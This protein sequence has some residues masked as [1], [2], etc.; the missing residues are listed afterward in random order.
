MAS[1]NET[2]PDEYLA[3]LPAE[4]REIVSAV[5]A[6]ILQHLPEGYVETVNW[7]ML[8]FEIPLS[9]FPATRNKQPLSYMALAANKTGYSLHMM[10]C[11]AAPHLLDDVK[12]WHDMEGKRFDMGKGCYRF[13]RLDDIP[14]HLIGAIVASTSVETM[15]ATAKQGW[16]LD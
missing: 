15:I 16:K 13:K 1:S 11:E 14:L 5:R 6:V 9:R 4:R 2:T 8:S 10:N 12:A 7:G 3:S